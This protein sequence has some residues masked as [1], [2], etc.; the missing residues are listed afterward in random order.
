MIVILFRSRLTAAAG[1]DY[2]AMDAELD[3]LVRG[4][5]GFVD[6]KSFTA[7]DG[8]RL[9]LVCGRTASLCCNGVTCRD[10]ARRS[11]P[12]ALNGMSITRWKSRKFFALQILPVKNLRLRTDGAKLP[13]SPRPSRARESLPSTGRSRFRYSSRPPYAATVQMPSRPAC[14]RWEC[15]PS[16]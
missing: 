7:A 13:P 12:A 1:A 4:Q 8:E 6:V 2:A 11:R 3:K 10:I 16:K 14:R 5:P 15:R 9:T